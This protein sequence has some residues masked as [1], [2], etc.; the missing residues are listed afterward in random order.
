MVKS[1]SVTPLYS[2]NQALNMVNCC[3]SGTFATNYLKQQAGATN[4]QSGIVISVSNIF[5]FVLGI[6][7][8]SLIDKN[9]RFNV[10]KIIPCM[11]VLQIASCVVL[12][13][14]PNNAPLAYVSYAAFS[15]F[16]GIVSPLLLKFYADMAHGGFVLDFGVA[17][18]IASAAFVI[19]SAVSGKVAE[20]VSVSVFPKIA[21]ATG[22]LNL[23]FH[24]VLCRQVMGKAKHET[25]EEEE[26]STLGQFISSNPRF[27]LLLAGI[28]CI[29]VGHYF[30]CNF[31]INV[32][33]NLGSDNGMMG[34]LGGFMALT[35][36]P[37]MMCFAKIKKGRDTRNLLKMS[38]IFFGLKCLAVALAPNIPLLF[39]AFILQAPSFA[40]YTP[41]I[42]E[43][44]KETLPHRDSGKAQSMAYG[45]LSLGQVIA[46]F[47]AGNLYDNMSVSQT[48][49]IGAAV[50]LFGTALSLLGLKKP[51]NDQGSAAV[52]G[53]TAF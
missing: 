18:G 37:V 14:F 8:S 50:A 25:V 22:I 4:S 35:E 46:G 43:Y 39:A 19:T 6:S 52:A 40:L 12:S 36:V 28:A 10:A 41:L 16:S 23:I 44:V 17:R 30:S 45:M 53:Q 5:C 15:T 27:C 2:I 29:F 1:K 24:F 51:K 20:K 9:R 49:L 34:L 7:L 38:L 33:N 48:L 3:I 11:I 31:L 13:V 47:V 32:V 26:G 42:V 21:I